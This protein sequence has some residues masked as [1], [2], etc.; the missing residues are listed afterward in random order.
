MRSI[1]A[2][3]KAA[4]ELGEAVKVALRDHL[5]TEDSPPSVHASFQKDGPDFTDWSDN[6]STHRRVMSFSVR[7]R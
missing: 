3:A 6:L 2:T 5:Y 1:A 4:I 7:W